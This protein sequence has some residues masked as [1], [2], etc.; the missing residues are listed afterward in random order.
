M[1]LG[2]HFALT[3]A[4]ASRFLAARGNDAALTALIDEL[5]E[6]SNTTPT[7]STDKAWDPISCA[8]AP[9]G[10][11]RDPDDWPYTGVIV[12][13]EELQHGAGKQ[14][15]D[16]SESES[17]MTLGYTPPDKVKEVAAA[18]LEL[19]EDDEFGDAYAAMPQELRNAEYGDEERRYAQ[20]NLDDLTE[21]FMDAAARGLHVI[22]HVNL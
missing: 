19:K 14:A 2:V 1:Q 3:E 13:W 6:S 12:G 7:C 10:S 11:E 9:S 4:Q 20:A 18:L 15:E 16:E 5:E 22:F 21:F 17:E 8:L